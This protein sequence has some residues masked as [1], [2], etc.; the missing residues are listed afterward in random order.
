MINVD[1][2]AIAEKLTKEILIR[3]VSRTTKSKGVKINT[4]EILTDL[5]CIS[6][7]YDLDECVVIYCFIRLWNEGKVINYNFLESYNMNRFEIIPIYIKQY[8]A[9]ISKIQNKF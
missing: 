3:E 8:Y 9:N 5:R 4:E 6:C 7:L 2:I 1:K